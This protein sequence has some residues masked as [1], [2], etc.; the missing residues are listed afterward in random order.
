MSTHFTARLQITK[1]SKQDLATMP[2]PGANPPSVAREK[3]QQ[4]DLTVRA[5]NL[6]ELKKKLSGH[7]DLV[8]LKDLEEDEDFD[9]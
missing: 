8:D 6:T 1:V 4:L 7:I 9:R 5:D 3:R 2:R